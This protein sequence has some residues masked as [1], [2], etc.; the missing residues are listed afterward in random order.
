[1]VSKGWCVLFASLLGGEW[2]RYYI[3]SILFYCSE[4]LLLVRTIAA[5]HVDLQRGEVAHGAVPLA[6]RR[7]L[8]HHDRGNVRHE[9][10][11]LS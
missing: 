1:M 11:Y 5:S 10:L 6:L 3:L 2:C 8:R 9:Q 7:H 4:G